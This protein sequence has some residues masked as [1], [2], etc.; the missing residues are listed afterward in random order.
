MQSNSSAS[1]QGAQMPKEAVAAG[2]GPVGPT[3][4]Q[5]GQPQQ[6]SGAVMLQQRPIIANNMGMQPRPQHPQLLGQQMHMG[7]FE[8]QPR[9]PMGRVLSAPLGQQMVP[10]T[11]PI[12]YQSSQY[13]MNQGFPG[14]SSQ[15]CAR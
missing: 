12:G 10:Q 3:M 2:L 9:P 8:Q 6:L 15:G 5:V 7:M 1:Y 13:F 4:N 14:S 11:P